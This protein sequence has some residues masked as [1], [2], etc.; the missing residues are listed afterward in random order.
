MPREPNERQ[1]RLWENTIVLGLRDV[2]WMRFI[3]DRSKKKSL[4]LANLPISTYPSR[5]IKFD[6]NAESDNGD[7]GLGINEKLFLIEVKST[8]DRVIDEWWR[9]GKFKPKLLYRRLAGLVSQCNKKTKSGSLSTSDYDYT[10]LKYSLQCHLITY[11]D[12]APATGGL[13]SGLITIKPYLQAMIESLVGRATPRRAITT[14]PPQLNY[15]YYVNKGRKLEQTNFSSQQLGLD[16]VFLGQERPNSTPRKM[17]DIGLSPLAFQ[18]YVNFLTAKRLGGNDPIN[19]VV[20]STHGG[21]VQVVSD[22]SQ[23]ANILSKNFDRQIALER[24]RLN[25]APDVAS[26]IS[27]KST[28]KRG[29]P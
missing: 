6:G 22:T 14:L 5:A 26:P 8:K 12:G 29:H 24:L 15:S 20:Q 16:N 2:Q 21:F 9:N 23:L 10:M 27:A 3:E 1:A 25:N 19:A 18:L 11:W 4:G 28:I 13:T 17:G 7:L